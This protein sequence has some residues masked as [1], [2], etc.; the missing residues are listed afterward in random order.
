MN[1]TGTPYVL[2][3]ELTD[4][5]EEVRSAPAPVVPEFD[6][7]FGLR[8]ADPEGG[9][10]DMLAEW[11]A[12]PH[13]LETWE[14]DW[15]ANRRRLDFLAQLAGTYS[16]P[17]ILSYDFAAI[18]RPE[19]GRRDIAYV[20][21]YRAAKDENGRLYDAD[22]LDMGFHIAT[23][24][25]NL[26]GRGVMSGWMDRLAA[27]LFAAE[28]ACRRL[29]CDPDYRNAPMRKALLKN[30]WVELGEFDVRP[31]RRIALHIMPRTAAD[32]PA[33]RL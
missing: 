10:P 7:P 21:I 30:G 19:L 1:Q 3:R 11:M 13:L 9:D 28:P 4:V 33:I 17:C 20:E 31:D 23:A 8:L 15:P 16:R 27:A 25:S 12:L 14:Q 22:P 29:I 5:A 18:D 2:K 26:I 32:M 24:D 6:E